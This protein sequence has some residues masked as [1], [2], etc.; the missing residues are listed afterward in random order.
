[1]SGYYPD[2]V[3][4]NEFAIA[5]PDG[6]IDVA[7]QTVYCNN[8]NCKQ[9][10]EEQDVDIIDASYYGRTAWGFWDCKF[11]DKEQEWEGELPQDDYYPED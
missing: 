3:T 2:G 10:D 8:E 7:G 4:G 5:G 9:F 11:C 6:E 1:M